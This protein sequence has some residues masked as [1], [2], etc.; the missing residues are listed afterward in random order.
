MKT[1]RAKWQF[2]AIKNTVSVM[3]NFFNEHD[4]RQNVNVVEK[5]ISRNK[6]TSKY[7]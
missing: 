2:C 4:K 7:E 3:K 5:A 1:D 6:S